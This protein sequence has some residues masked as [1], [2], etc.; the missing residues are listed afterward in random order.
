MNNYFQIAGG[1]GTIQKNKKILQKS[2]KQGAKGRLLNTRGKLPQQVYNNIR[3]G[4]S[5]VKNKFIINI[6][7]LQRSGGPNSRTEAPKKYFEGLGSIEQEI[8]QILKFK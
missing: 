6:G 4:D 5:N 7:N 8:Q 3:M 1:Q 2:G